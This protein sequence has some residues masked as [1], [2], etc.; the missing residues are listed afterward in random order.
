MSDRYAPAGPPVLF[1]PAGAGQ[2]NEGKR[3]AEATQT[4]GRLGEIDVEEGDG[5]EEDPDRDCGQRHQLRNRLDHLVLVVPIV[6]VLYGDVVVGRARRNI[7][8]FRGIIVVEV[9]DGVDAAAGALLDGTARLVF[10]LLTLLVASQ[11]SRRR[12]RAEICGPIAAS[13]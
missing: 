10:L 9:I 12:G 1:A 2:E 5:E 6:L 7:V 4:V 11:P 3:R 8:D 13:G